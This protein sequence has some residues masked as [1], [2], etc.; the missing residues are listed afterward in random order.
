MQ[1]NNT[2]RIIMALCAI[3]SINSL[4]AQTGPAGIGNKDGANSQPRNILW[5]DAAAIDQASGTEVATW[6]DVSGNGYNAT[7]TNMPDFVTNITN[8]N[9]VVRFTS[10]SSDFMNLN[11]AISTT[12]NGIAYQNFT[13]FAVGARR[14]TGTNYLIGGSG[15]NPRIYLGWYNETSIRYYFGTSNLSAN[16]NN[17]TNEPTLTT[18][19]Y[20]NAVSNNLALS[21]NAGSFS[22]TNTAYSLTGYNTPFLGRN[23]S[24]Y[25]NVDIAEVIFFQSALN[26]AQRSIV[27]NYLAAKYNLI[28]TG[29]RFSGN[30]LNYWRDFRGIG[31]E[32]DGKVISG[33]SGGFSITDSTSLA[34][35][36]YVMFAHN[37]IANAVSTTDIPTTIT[38]RW[39]RDW[40]VY[41]T[42]TISPKISFNFQEGITDG[43]F[44]QEVSN[45]RLLYRSGTT[46]EYSIVATNSATL[47]S[48]NTI[49][50][51]VPNTSLLNG[52]YTLGTIDDS[53][54]P[55]VG[56]ESVTYYTLISG[57][58]NNPEIWTLDPSGMI[59][60]NPGNNYPN[61]ASDNVVIKSGKE[62]TMNIN[63]ATNHNVTVQGILNLNTTTGHHFDFIKGN[64]RIFMAADNF[65]SGDATHFISTD[66][67]AGTAV[68]TGNSFTT[69]QPRTFY[70]VEV[71]MNA[72]QTLT[73]IANITI[74]HNLEIKTGTLQLN[75][76]VAT[77]S[78][79][80][81]ISNNLTILEDGALSVGNG[82][83]IHRINIYGDIENH[84][85]IDL[86]N[87][88]QYA[89]P[90]NGAATLCFLGA[91]N[92]TFSIDGN[93]ELYRLVVSKGT[94][95][96]YSIALNSTNSNWM[97]LM[98]PVSGADAIEAIDGAAAWQQLPLVIQNGTLQA[99]NN[100]TIDKLCGNRTG[101]A[102]NDFFIPSSAM[103]W[104]DGA[105]LTTSLA[106][107]TTN[108][109]TINGTLKISAG[110]L[111]IPNGSSGIKYD[112]NAQGVGTLL[113]NG[114]VITSTQLK[115]YTPTSICNY[116]QA[117]GE[118][119][120][121][122]AADI[123]SEN[124]VFS[125]P[126]TTCNFNM[127]GGLIT[128]GAI[129][130][131]STNAIHIGSQSGNYNIEG[132]SISIEAP[133]T[134]SQTPT[135]AT[136]NTTTPFYNLLFSKGTNTNNLLVQLQRELTILNDLTIGEFAQLNA[137]AQTLN[138]GRNFN[139][140]NNG[141]YLTGSNTTNFIGSQNSI[142][143]IGNSDI[144]SPLI[145]SNLTINKDLHPNSNE[146]Y[147]VSIA[148]CTGRQSNEDVNSIT[149]LNTIITVTGVFNLLRGNMVIDRYSLNVANTVSISDGSFIN[150][151]APGRLV[152]TEKA[153]L[154]ST[155]PNST[156]FGCVEMY[157]KQSGAVSNYAIQSDITIDQL[158][159]QREATL[160]IYDYRLTIGAGGIVTTNAFSRKRM[161]V[162]SRTVDAKGVRM[163]VNISGNYLN[164]D[165]IKRFPIGYDGTV[166]NPYVPIE[167]LAN[168]NYSPANPISGYIT[169][170]PIYGE[171]PSKSANGTAL[172]FY[173]KVSSTG[174]N[175]IDPSKVNFRAF[176][177]SV[178]VDPAINTPFYLI[179]T[180]WQSSG[181]ITQLS[182]PS[183]FAIEFGSF[184]IPSQAELTA[185]TADA[186]SAPRTL[187]STGN[188]EFM[189]NI[190]STQGHNG[191]DRTTPLPYDIVVIGGTNSRNDSIWVSSSD[192]TITVAKLIIKNSQL[193]LQNGSSPT[194]DM[195]SSKLFNLHSVSGG[196]KVRRTNTGEYGTYSNLSGDWDGFMYN[197]SAKFEYY[198]GISG[199]YVLPPNF[200]VYPTLIIRGVYRELTQFP[201]VDITILKDLIL[202]GDYI[203]GNASEHPVA[204][205]S[206]AN[207]NVTVK[208]NLILKNLARLRFLSYAEDNKVRHFD[209]IATGRSLRIQGNIM[210]PSNSVCYIE[211]E[212]LST[213]PAFI[214]SDSED[215]NQ[216]L[217]ENGPK[218]THNLYVGGNID[219][220]RSIFF[221]YRTR[222][223][224]TDETVLNM[225]FDG[226]NNSTIF[227]E[228]VNPNSPFNL[229]LNRLTINKSVPTANVYLLEEFSLKA[230]A[231]A[232]SA[233]KPLLL[234]R[235]NLYI[236]NSRVNLL[237]SSGND[238]FKIPST[239]SLHVS[240]ASVNISGNNT[241][242]WLDGLME[243]G[244][245]S[246]WLLNG[247]T[248]NY[249][250][251]SA[252]GNAAILVQ[253]GTLRVGSQIRRS[254]TSD[255]GILS[256]TQNKAASIIVIGDNSIP[257]TANNRAM[258][259]IL[260]TG[261]SFVQTEPNSIITIGRGQSSANV[262]DMLLS[263]ETYTMP[264][265]S[266]FILGNSTTPAGT[267]FDIQSSVPLKN[268]T[269]NSANSP[270]ARLLILPL[271]IDENLT[272][273]SGST[274]DANS[275]NLFLKGNFTNSGTYTPGTNTTYFIGSTDQTVSGSINFYNLTKQTT[276]NTL[277]FT[278]TSSVLTV[279]GN[280]TL[281][282]GTLNLNSNTLQVKRNVNSIIPTLS[283]GSS[284]GILFNGTVNQVL[285]GG[286][287]FSTLTINNSQGV[288]VPTEGE[289]TT[290]T[291]KL[292]L[293]NGVLDIGKNLL[294]LTA[295]A[296]IEEVSPFSATNMIQTYISFTDAGIKKYF[297]TISTATSFTYPIGS[298][299]KY[300]P[301]LLDITSLTSSTGYIRV[302][303]ANERHITINNR[304]ETAY[305]DRENVLAYYWTLDAGNIDEFTA[306]AT[307]DSYAGDIKTTAGN[308]TADYITARLLDASAGTLNKYST[309]DFNEAVNELYFRFI[310]ADDSGIDG[311]Y[312]A[313]VDNAIPNNIPAYQTKQAGNWS[314]ASTWDTYPVTG[315]SIPDG[316]PRGN[317]VIINHPTT[318]NTNYT[319]SYQTTI[320]S[321]GSLNTG[322]T[323]GNRLGNVSG[324]GRLILTTGNMPAGVYD[325]F[326][327][328]TGGTL[329]YNGTGIQ[330]ILSE[331][332][333]VN[334]LIISGT[335][336]KQLPN[337]PLTI[338][339]DLTINGSILSNINDIYLSVHKNIYYLAGGFRAGNGRLIMNGSTRQYIGGSLSFTG[340]NRQRFFEINNSAGI[341]LLQPLTI[342]GTLTLTN[343][344]IY[345]SATN[346]LT[347]I[348]S[349]ANNSGGKTT[350]YVNGP[351]VLTLPLQ[352]SS[353]FLF[354]VGK[355]GRYAPVTINGSGTAGL[356][357]A[358]FY[359]NSPTNN[360]LYTD[361]LDESL[362]YV[363]H[364]EFWRIMGPTTPS[365]IEGITLSCDAQS[366]AY[367]ED[368]ELRIAQWNSTNNWEAITIWGYSGTNTNGTAWTNQSE[369]FNTTSSGN[370]FTFGYATLP[371]YRWTGAIS[372]DWFNA[373]N[374]D[375]KQ[376]PTAIINTII[377][378]T[379]NQPVVSGENIAECS[380][381]TINTNASLTVNPGGKMTVEGNIVNNGSLILWNTTT[382]PSSFIHYKSITD[383]LSTGNTEIRRQFEGNRAWYIGNC[384]IDVPYS[385]FT[386]A[387]PIPT[388]AAGIQLMYSYDT[389]S[390]T[391]IYPSAS[392]IL[393][394]MTGYSVNFG[395][396]ASYSIIQKGK[397]FTGNQTTTVTS[398][399]DR[400]NL[401]ANPFPSYIGFSPTMIS[402]WDVSNI[403]P[404]IYIRTKLNGISTYYT[405]NLPT[406]TS[407][408]EGL[409]YLA[410]MQAF[411]VRATRSGS[412]T[413]NQTARIHPVSP[414]SLK[415]A[416]M[417][418]KDILRITSNN[419]LAGDETVIVFRTIGN[420]LPSMMDSEKKLESTGVIPQIY[421]IKNTKNIA[422][423]IMPDD[424]TSYSIPL[425]ITVGAKGAG[426]I[427]LTASNINSFMPGIDVY[428][429]DLISGTI[430]NL[431][432]SPSY[433]F[434][435]TAV[436]TQTRFE[437]F[438]KKSTQ[439]TTDIE[440]EPVDKEVSIKA[441]AIDN[442]AVVTINDYAFTGNVFIEVYESTG[443][444]ISKQTSMTQQTEIEMTDNTQL[445]ILKVT[446]QNLSQS[447][448][449][450]NR[451]T[452]H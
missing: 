188:G 242:I 51:E 219:I 183:Q 447:F 230:D 112:N 283:N 256:F 46:G 431:R 330:N 213:Y 5:L 349:G 302:K 62:V 418:P 195:G 312:F 49:A 149:D 4:L 67:G 321:S 124:A 334:N 58:W 60:N 237:L 222:T 45:Y 59:P 365:Q 86:S 162:T 252:S 85:S 398:N 40:Y 416:E 92:N 36:S 240:N 206:S 64:G 73:T 221:G 126:N 385:T 211:I 220:N 1:L 97:K 41:K 193:I 446:Y 413:I 388:P 119:R 380:N 267:V 271:T 14:T 125:L 251:Y 415:V 154:Y 69:A 284:Q 28:I 369:M 83:A 410:P 89:T 260:N 421:S 394:P 80:L 250:E 158:I 301:V 310:N 326:F 353:D 322:T 395:T 315:G 163:F 145:F 299:G 368:S 32:S 340:S 44:P 205:N 286:G 408:P 164:N 161:I 298:Q 344:I 226:D 296:Q 273:N 127:T 197:D 370:Y 386:N 391:W 199:S 229:R 105:N 383:G 373:D 245:N 427:T 30:P 397:L 170:T 300:T 190:W 2:I 27:T 288:L 223:G 429:R 399:G 217:A 11:G 169:V 63:N 325:N 452:Y 428:L 233:E 396:E 180:S 214:N 423:N 259:E 291:N 272:I 90:T 346:K 6:P 138:I 167:L 98:G 113:I 364:N 430:T 166:D 140:N 196:G 20:N 191:N 280:L 153:R 79:S 448:K 337:N 151:I 61:L 19:I 232:S 168:G 34:V 107:E 121:S 35:G 134:S 143:N 319:T 282:S 56:K 290:I 358:E 207:G 417:K 277:S 306:L 104:I 393:K 374:W 115:Q 241:G 48:V 174:F 324:Q 3:F 371:S 405:V 266:T 351:L 278:G 444:L 366:L 255:A 55:L 215:R 216:S 335:G 17:S 412:F 426:N 185:A 409:N 384:I 261:S 177:G 338:M 33:N 178:V 123:T 16:A 70:N 401:I 171:H 363:S 203:G 392:D 102:P 52:Y 37:E 451:Q 93:T 101:N 24:N 218:I 187:Y 314:D 293:Q 106:G 118:F 348:L 144:T 133:L 432:Q 15:S 331:I 94:D 224:R 275:L 208:G 25:Y 450:T 404:S 403:E 360:G 200:T 21:V 95:K 155:N 78:K 390:K 147:S 323:I 440:H 333:T 269:I 100:I 305:D 289:S 354:P 18:A 268:L 389:N 43:K 435:T 129:N 294:T 345:T 341:E 292:R 445:V 26:S 414:Q 72:G 175:G 54:S 84:G 150:N 110:S 332:T 184:A 295:S 379:A 433:S 209:Q 318:I 192:A 406:G 194:F 377:N 96:T 156:T 244:S 376:L 329:E 8:G 146:R 202:S 382:S 132:G 436:N 172:P 75:N 257:A 227:S 243:V 439:Q 443:K 81:T 356:W 308:S 262:P 381:L 239:A 47:E 287:T 176:T 343:G 236:D 173:W 281:L 434:T 179:S 270:T 137:N 317:V 201:I 425:A 181:T 71:D 186:F 120:I 279:N 135:I 165:I 313:G 350:S 7:A 88:A 42:G 22:N 285:S 87:S 23:N 247:G 297:P 355:D 375:Y 265:G 276:T 117:G 212:D 38:S 327:A 361:N 254:L 141:S 264:T 66:Q 357:E 122:G 309:D 76:D 339:G 372:T 116:S 402:E 142:I 246:Q 442:K 157:G 304:P 128:I 29:D 57:N 437:L 400:W 387:T 82:N 422:I 103:L 231:S 438:F 189:S 449:I 307:L 253:D 228:V 159:M 131:F 74:N 50:F 108:G 328:E 419:S 99:G 210:T 238:C 274:F 420:K 320:Q 148:E 441:F 13:C 111:T 77:T 12:T 424:P 182:S 152:L 359:N 198:G 367:L 10:G 316:G 31:Q 225:T 362:E 311:D 234:N 235:G 303:S 258:F 407:I 263:P 378:Q 342:N 9:P 130:T 109:V 53:N 347:N 139:L 249:I 68:F 39:L 411:Y 248:N 136:I 204:L 65:P 352:R 114:G 91:T 336:T 160:T